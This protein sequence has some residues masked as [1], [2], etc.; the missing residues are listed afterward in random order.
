MKPLFFLSIF[1]FSGITHAERVSYNATAF[2]VEFNGEEAKAVFDA[3]SVSGAR[4][5][6]FNVS[7]DKRTVFYITN[8]K[9]RTHWNTAFDESE[10]CFKKPAYEISFQDEKANS[11]KVVMNESLDCN[12]TKAKNLG[13]ILR[14]LGGDKVE[15][16]AMGKSMFF[17]SSVLA[18]F[19][20]SKQG[21]KQYSAHLSFGGSEN[22]CQ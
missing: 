13:K 22:T 16:A 21:K 4:G 17:S 12:E 3:I 5:E 2:D 6:T 18:Y 20:P 1:L 9:V 15:D 7:G 11:A 14:N 19:D 10:P 8:V